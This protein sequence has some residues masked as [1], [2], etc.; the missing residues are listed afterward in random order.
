MDN[1]MDGHSDNRMDKG[2]VWLYENTYAKTDKHPVK[3]GPGE[4]SREVLKKL[5]DRIKETGGDTVKIQCAAW[6]RVS[7]N[8]NAYTFTT[9]EVAED[10][11]NR[12]NGRAE[13]IPF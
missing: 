8:G 10:K 7:K 2:R 4:I 1:R 3:T 6:E 11:E 9:M 13:E 5:V 12:P